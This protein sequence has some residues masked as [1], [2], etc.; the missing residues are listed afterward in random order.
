MR[1]KDQRICRTQRAHQ[2]RT[3]KTLKAPWHQGHCKTLSSALHTII[4]EA[5]I[6]QVGA[7]IQLLQP[8][9]ETVHIETMPL[10]QAFKPYTKQSATNK[11]E[12]WRT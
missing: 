1:K 12:F 4:A 9:K 6:K 10:Y 2:G 8:E 11:S 3:Q 5:C 7:N